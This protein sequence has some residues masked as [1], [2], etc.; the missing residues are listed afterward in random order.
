MADVYLAAMSGPVGF[1]KLIVIKRLREDIVD[2]SDMATMLLDEAQLAARLQHPNVVQ[3]F[4]VGMHEGKH[5]IA[6][7]YLEG[8]SLGRIVKNCGRPPHKFA[9]RVMVDALAGLEYAHTLEDYDGRPLSIVHRDVSPQ[10]L[11]VTYAGEVKVV[12]FGVAKAAVRSSEQTEQGVLKGKLGYMA[13]EQLKG[14]P[15]DRRTDVFAAGI[16]FWELLTGQRLF[17][18][19]HDGEAIAKILYATITLP[20]QIVPDIPHAIDAICMRALARRPTERWQTAGEM[21][22]A[23]YKYME[24]PPGGGMRRDEVGQYLFSHF[25]HERSEVKARIGEFM[26]EADNVDSSKPKDVG[27]LR[28]LM[29]STRPGASVP[30]SLP[31]PPTGTPSGTPGAAVMPSLPPPRSMAPSYA[32]AHPPSAHPPPVHPPPMRPVQST[33]TSTAFAARASGPPWRAIGVGAAFVALLA[34]TLVF[35]AFGW[36]GTQVKPAA[37]VDAGPIVAAAPLFTMQGSGTIGVEA[38]PALVEGYFRKRG[39]SDVRREVGPKPDDLRIIATMPQ[40]VETVFVR[41]EGT[42]GGFQ[43][44]GER[45]C[46]IAMAAREIHDDEAALLIAKGNADPRSLASEHVIGLDGVAVVVNASSSI[47]ALERTQ[48]AALYNGSIGDWSG[49]GRVPGGPVSLIS[50]ERGSGTFDVFESLVLNGQ[51]LSSTVR[52]LPDNAKIEGTVAVEPNAIGFLGMAFVR[53]SR[54]LAIGDRGVIPMVPSPFTVTTE[55]YLLSRRLYFYTPAQPSPHVLEFMDY[56][57]S[58]E[59]QRAMRTSGFIDLDV[60]VKNAEPCERCTARY[61]SVTKKARR[62]SL[63]FR[64]RGATKQLDARAV[65]DVDRVVRFLREHATSKILLVG[66]CDSTGEQKADKARSRELAQAVDAELAARGVRASVI[67]G[68]GG[69]MPI[70]SNAN[71]WGRS[72]NRRVEIW[73][74]L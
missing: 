49:V 25:E 28:T 20:S 26:H 54:A 69:E 2:R 46:E 72:K 63:D 59:G 61:A 40:G 23:L 38:A 14:E 24:A 19:S 6:M 9:V 15:C 11:F 1:R 36:P 47:R 39:A 10:N 44:L 62:L 60:S 74:G 48:I 58:S 53:A 12:D 50:H 67:D 68:F 52:M 13:P 64:F 56:V 73:V 30:V 29:I 16:V 18:G 51:P 71:D 43:C 31:P 27:S 34:G 66:F 42:S 5:Y 41:S 17:R 4:E 37:T 55:R 21:R 32:S 65:R 70:A 3:T 22:E 45:T 33:S 8:Q 35:V 57:L 7:E